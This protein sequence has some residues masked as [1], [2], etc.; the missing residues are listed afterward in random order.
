MNTE[1]NMQEKKSFLGRR[2]GVVLFWVW[3][4]IMAAMILQSAGGSGMARIV[5][6]F[7]GYSFGVFG[8]LVAFFVTKWKRKRR[9]L[10]LL[11]LTFVSAVVSVESNFVV[12]ML[13]AGLNLWLVWRLLL[14][15]PKDRN[16]TEDDAGGKL[17]R[18]TKIY[19]YRDSKMQKASK[20]VITIGGVEIPRE[21]EPSHFLWAGGPGTGKSVG[22]SAMLEVIR[23]RNERAIVYDPTGEFLSQFYREGD[24]VLNPLDARSAP[25][26]PWSDASS[27]ADYEQIASGIIPD[28]ERQPFFPQSARAIL[29]SILG[30]VHTVQELLRLIMSA[31]SLELTE[32]VKR[33]GMGGLVGSDAT[34]ANSR[35]SMTAPTTCLRYLRDPRPGEK[36]FS[37]REWVMDEKANA[38]R[39]LFLTSRADQRAVLRPL[40]SLWIDVAVTGVMM[41]APSRERRIWLAVDELPSLQKMPKIGVAMAECR[42]YGFCVAAGIQSVAQLREP[43]T[44]D[45]AEA[46]L[47]LPQTQ[48]ILR[49]PDPDTAAWAS[50]AAGDRHIIR[51]VQGE[52][53]SSSGG[54]ESTTY[55]HATE[56]AILP[57]QIQALPALEGILKYPAAGGVVVARIRLVPKDRPTVAQAYIPATRD[58]GAMPAT[59]TVMAATPE[60]EE[61]PAGD[62][63]AADDPFNV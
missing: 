60:P 11:F 14:R 35:A 59:T 20:T 53:S 19:D 3:A 39:W 56:A 41:M 57:A 24:I 2:V 9:M 21:A 1:L 54:G 36:P 50:K 10:G 62:E 28:D 12:S 44:R 30:E 58:P 51:G 27:Q 55:Q 61:A 5:P 48:V 4:A 49:L 6:I 22:I 25:W 40:L 31:D 47:G 45:G 7:D 46:L 18:G 52:S 23:N 16:P 33:Q 42:K 15:R 43:Y 32:M 37:I 17:V 34:F 26:T 13:L 8:L 63:A 38:G 29:V